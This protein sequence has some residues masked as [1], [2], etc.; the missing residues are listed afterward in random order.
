[1]AATGWG[2]RPDEAGVTFRLPNGCTGKGQPFTGVCRMRGIV[3]AT[4]AL[5]ALTAPVLAQ[6]QN[7]NSG[8]SGWGGALDQLNRA[9]NPNNYP[10]DQ[11]G[12]RTDRR[13]EGTSGESRTASNGPY[14]RYSD[15]DLRDQ[16]D[17]VVDEQRQ[18]Q[19]DRRS[20]E[21]EME[22]RGLRR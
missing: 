10:Q 5:L 4:A 8:N 13:Y 9:V 20:M 7:N 15:R 6:S 3:L 12:N 1:M 11:D 19:R 18:L 14:R 16:Y 2:R 21:E 22:R 17:R